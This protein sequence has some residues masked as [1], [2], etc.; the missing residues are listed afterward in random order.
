[1]PLWPVLKLTS[2]KAPAYS[3]KAE[4]KSNAISS[5]D[6]E[7]SDTEP[8]IKGYT[9]AVPRSADMTLDLRDTQKHSFGN[10]H[11]SCKYHQQ[12]DRKG[13][14]AIDATRLT[15]M[16]AADEDTFTSVN[17]DTPAANEQASTSN[18]TT[19]T[20]TSGQSNNEMPG[21][22]LPRAP[23][24][25]ATSTSITSSTSGAALAGIDP[26]S[27]AKRA[28]RGDEAD[29]K[30]KRTPR[31]EGFLMVQVTDPRKEQEGTK[32]MFVSYG[33]RAETNLRHF[34]RT[35][36]TTRR[37]FQDFVFLREHLSKDFPACVVPPLPDKHRLEYLTGD[38]FNNEFL[39]RRTQD[40]QLF[41]ERVSRHPTLQRAQL[42]RSF[43]ES[44][45]WQVDMHSHTS[46]SSNL[47]HGN[48]EGSS[49]G[50]LDSLTDTFMTAFSRVRKPDEKFEAMRERLERLEE[51]LGNT[52]RV[53]QRT[54]SR[55]GGK[56]DFIYNRS[57][58]GLQFADAL[59]RNFHPDLS[60]LLLLLLLQIYPALLRLD[61]LHLDFRSC[62]PASSRLNPTLPPIDL[63]CNPRTRLMMLLLLLL[64]LLRHHPLTLP[65][66]LHQIWVSNHK[67][68]RRIMKIWPVPLRGL[69]SWKV[70][71]PNH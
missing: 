24:R 52:E 8:D 48:G 12:I 47:A 13:H 28:S 44:S 14:S 35:R 10:P 57:T 64:P 6:V 11:P 63:L 23:H 59:Q 9:I 34:Q 45:E 65:N 70:A 54:R 17:W 7:Q 20:T 32:E 2:Q 61:L 27:L 15:T 43:L 30:E 58:S 66:C 37:R 50:I 33:I 4:Q 41:L 42:L 68:W 69:V 19:A 39:E 49:G 29:E 1:M 3:V 26:A 5:K 25:T 51:G 56:S 36:M 60:L 40:L 31:W 55:H 46:H 16:N 18:P 38:R 71:S 21:T 67:I 22:S 53:I 62:A